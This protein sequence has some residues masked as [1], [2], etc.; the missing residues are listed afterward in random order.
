MVN[1]KWKVYGSDVLLKKYVRRRLMQ[2]LG[3]LII[4]WMS[5]PGISGIFFRSIYFL[6]LKMTEWEC[7]ICRDDETVIRDVYNEDLKEM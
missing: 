7:Y 1:S 6:W 3:N 4:C 5:I 2:Q